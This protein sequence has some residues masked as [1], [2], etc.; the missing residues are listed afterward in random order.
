MRDLHR[1]PAPN[2]PESQEVGSR[3]LRHS[4]ILSSLD[5]S[6]SS[7]TNPF[8]IMPESPFPFPIMTIEELIAGLSEGINETHPTATD[9][10]IA[11]TEQALK[12]SLPESFKTLVKTFSN[13]GNI[14]MLQELNSVGNRNK[15]VLPLQKIFIGTAK[16][17][18]RVPFGDEDLEGES[19]AFGSLVPFSVDSNGNAWCF[20]MD[21]PENPEPPVAYLEVLS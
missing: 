4:V 18:T 17:E 21:D 15:V 9:E 6:H 8:P 16:A 11:T 13:G 10:D 3:V 2:L 1:S 5:I 14:F 20:I 12:R 19:V 7:F